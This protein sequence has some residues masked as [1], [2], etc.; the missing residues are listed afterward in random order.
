MDQVKNFQEFKNNKEEKQTLTTKTEQQPT[1]TTTTTRGETV[2][3]ARSS[4]EEGVGL[5][6]TRMRLTDRDRQLMGLL[7]TARHL[8][9]DQVFR[10][11]FPGLNTSNTR[12]RL[13]RLAGFGAKSFQPPY[14][15]RQHYRTYEGRLV[16]VWSLAEL[17]YRIAEAVLGDSVK[18]LRKEVGANFLEHEVTVNELFVQLARPE[19]RGHA[20]ARLK[21]WAWTAG[22]HVRLAWTQFDMEAGKSR[23]RLI[24]P[25][26]IL[27]NQPGRRRIFIECER[28]GHSIWA[29][30]DEK[31]GSTLAK[32]ERYE[33]YLST[34]V[35]PGAQETYY[36]RTY[37]DGWAPEL[38]FLVPSTT[39]GKNIRAAIEAWRRKKVRP[40]IQ[41]R[42]LPLEEAVAYIKD[43]AF[44]SAR[45]DAPVS[46]GRKE[47]MMFRQFF[48]STISTLKDLR[49]T[50]RMAGHPVPDYPPHSG[51]IKE[52]L[53]RL[54]DPSMA[55][56]PT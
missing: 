43:G 56:R 23:D 4:M 53:S 1:T 50:S 24:C 11:C 12:K 39:R 38:L 30:S 2:P 5:P 45:S 32:L 36:S 13:L 51:E 33:G 14:L 29:L 41:V 26:A 15:R 35:R 19:S 40:R 10:L 21:G 9:E 25:D 27:E 49:A 7:A 42:A 34:R 16:V 46:F 54:S 28:G 47:L 3:A 44:H 48:S 22:D 6:R 55:G 8:A 52:L 37:P 20:R 31:N 18:V 17:G